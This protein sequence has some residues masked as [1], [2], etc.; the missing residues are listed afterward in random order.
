MF[1][2]CP[3]SRE[4]K[5]FTSHSDSSFA[6][7]S[8]RLSYQF[9]LNLLCLFRIFSSSSIFPIFFFFRRFYIS[10]FIQLSAT[11]HVSLQCYFASFFVATFANVHTQNQPKI[12]QQ[13]YF[14]HF[15]LTEIN[16]SWLENST[17]DLPAL[18]F[19]V[20]AFFCVSFSLYFN[21]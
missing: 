2:V 12:K 1:N 13:Y 18:N 20:L 11:L 15:L 17:R 8:L 9:Y 19:H 5:S 21:S 4:I 3:A 14:Y 10:S 16:F 6:Y 7:L